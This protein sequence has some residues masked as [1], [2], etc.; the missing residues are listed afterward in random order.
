MGSIPIRF[1]QSMLT[2]KDIGS[3]S[4]RNVPDLSL[5]DV[6]DVRLGRKVAI[7]QGEACGR[8]GLAN[9]VVPVEHR[10]R[11][12]ATDLHGDGRVN[13]RPDEVSDSGAA[14]IME[15]PVGGFAVERALRQSLSNALS[16]CPN[17]PFLVRWKMRGQSS[18]RARMRRSM[19]ERTSP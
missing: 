19:I 9:D 13:A 18:R 4:K 3:H 5:F 17:W 12:V 16:G 2:D 15:D 6:A 7:S 10:A 8:L 14:E 1:R 11:P